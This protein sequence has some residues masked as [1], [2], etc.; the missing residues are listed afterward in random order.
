MN[1]KG[2]IFDM[3][4]TLTDSMHVWRNLGELYLVSKGIVPEPG[5]KEKIWSMT[6]L[7]GAEYMKQRYGLQGNPEQIVK[8]VYQ[9]IEDFYRTEVQEKPGVRR[10]L[11]ELQQAGI[12]MCVA[13]A[14]DTYLVEYA[15]A[16][17][18]LRSYFQKI[19]CCREVG[20]GKTTDKI[21]QV[22]RERLGTSVEETWIFEDALYAARTAKKAGFPLVAIYDATED[23]HEE[24]KEIADIYL[25]SYEQWPGIQDMSKK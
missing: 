7:D 12:P 4:G 17:T 2:A 15:L 19:Y 5:L 1:I 25:N 14:T 18:G 24:M 23:G 20:E 8:E 13:S 9:L 6:M 22:A 10:I 11:E 3:D 21:Y 16:H